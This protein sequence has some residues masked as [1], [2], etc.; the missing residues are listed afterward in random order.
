MILTQSVTVAL[1]SNTNLE[2]DD[3]NDKILARITGFC[4]T[5][6]QVFKTVS[7]G[8]T[9]KRW[10]LSNYYRHLNKHFL[11]YD[12]EPKK[13]KG[14]LVINTLPTN[15]IQNYFSP[16]QYSSNN[17][18]PKLCCDSIQEKEEIPHTIISN[19]T[20]TTSSLSTSKWKNPKYNRSN[21]EK[22]RYEKRILSDN[23]KTITY[24]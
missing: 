17:K 7:R 22:R 5:S 8:H 1:S 12:L 4:G 21:R 13:T 18:N 3:I 23:K 10:I 19:A 2:N 11:N 15:S 14:K 16:V 6:S 20:K 24:N 9:K